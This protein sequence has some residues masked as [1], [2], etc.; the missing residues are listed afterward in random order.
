M[1]WPDERG[2][3]RLAASGTRVGT[4]AHR[5]IGTSAHRHIGTSAHRHIGTSAHRHIGTSAHRHINEDNAAARRFRGRPWA[6]AVVPRAARR[7][8]RCRPPRPARA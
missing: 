1:G 7:R 3:G 6:S 8:P 5:H 2:G 4:S